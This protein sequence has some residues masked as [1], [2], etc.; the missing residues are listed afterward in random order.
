MQFPDYNTYPCLSSMDRYQRHRLCLRSVGDKAKEN[1]GW[2]VTRRYMR[3]SVFK[4]NSGFHRMALSALA[5]N[6]CASAPPV[7]HSH[8]C[9]SPTPACRPHPGVLQLHPYFVATHASA[10]SVF[11]PQPRPRRA[12]APSVL[13]SHE[14]L[15]NVCFSLFSNK[16]TNL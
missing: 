12:S 15:S 14:C 16:F 13:E 10:P 3:K 1:T 4:I 6:I 8:P 9:F 11:Q 5:L 7:L 2:Y